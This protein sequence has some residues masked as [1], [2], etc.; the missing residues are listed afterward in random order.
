[1]AAR[2]GRPDAASDGKRRGGAALVAGAIGLYYLPLN[3]SYFYG[4]GRSGRQMTTALPFMALGSGA[5]V[6]S[7]PPGDAHRCL[8]M[9]LGCVP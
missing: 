4:R 9:D 3:A 7:R 1:M 6:G 5:A 8:R 2:A